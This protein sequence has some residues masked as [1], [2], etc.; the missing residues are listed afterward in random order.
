LLRAVVA[1]AGAAVASCL[2][3]GCPG[4]LSF[5]YAPRDASGADHS[6]VVDDAGVP[7][8]C[9]DAQSILVASCSACHTNPPQ[10]I[11]ANLD[12][13]SPGVAARLVGVPAYT[14]ASGACS[15]KGDLLD[16]GHLPATG[17]LMDK[18]NFTQTCGLGMPYGSG[19]PLPAQDRTC[20][21]AWANGLVAGTGG[22]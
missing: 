7:V 13:I 14:G 15:G 19:M 18:L 11:Y 4:S 9:A 6:I 3:A 22:P 10:P 5:T 20:L 16:A 21:Q 1:A 8:G 2:L 17:I 12:L